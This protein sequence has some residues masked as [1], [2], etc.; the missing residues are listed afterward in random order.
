MTVPA[1]QESK[2]PWQLVTDKLKSYGAARR[3]IMPSV[4]PNTVRSENHRAA[5]SGV[6][7]FRLAALRFAARRLLVFFRGVLLRGAAIPGSETGLYYPARGVADGSA[8]H[9]SVPPNPRTRL[10]TP[11]S[12]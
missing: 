5:A 11:S 3:T 8:A 7:A 2:L 12:A 1:G 4:E 6:V 10:P 9:R